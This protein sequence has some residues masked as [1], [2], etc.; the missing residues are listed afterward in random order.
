M[1]EAFSTDHWRTIA[2]NSQLSSV[3]MGAPFGTSKNFPADNLPEFSKATYQNVKYFRSRR[4]YKFGSW[5]SGRQY[6][7]HV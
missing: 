2:Y 5:R 7:V 1:L 3:V 4:Q 6:A